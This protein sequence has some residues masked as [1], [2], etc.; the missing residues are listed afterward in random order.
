MVPSEALAAFES[1]VA[2]HY[3]WN[4]RANL[5]YGLFGTTGLRLIAAPTFVPDYL[6]KLGG[7][8]LVVGL[9]LVVGG[10]CRF[11][12]PMFA[13]AWV[14]HRSHVKPYS[15]AIGMLM[16]VAILGFALAALVLPPATNLIAFIVCLGLFHFSDGMQTVAYS[17]VMGKVIP[18]ARRGR[19]IGL[20]DFLGGTTVA[21]LSLPMGRLLERVPFP[22][23]YGVMFLI[24]LALTAIGLVC[25]SLTR[26][27]P[28]P[29]PAEPQSAIDTLRRI[30]DVLRQDRRFASY[31]ASRA[32]GTAALTATPF[33]V[34]YAQSSLALTGTRLGEFTFLFFLAQTVVNPLWGRLA[35]GRGFR[36]VSLVAAGVWM[37]AAALLVVA[38]HSPLLVGI[39]FAIVGIGHGGYRMAAVNMVF[40]FGLDARFAQRLA[41]VSMIGELVGAV[42]PLGTGLLADHAG[43]PAALLS[44][45]M[46]MAIAQVV[47]ALGVR[48]HRPM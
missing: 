6:Y 7:S 14:A 31:C 44:A 15:V 2:R 21:V 48:G 30:P 20:R 45:V 12:G 28:A 17:L 5:V 32:L 23:S 1:A 47:M 40:E 41:A 29:W 9:A 18:L 34:L 24:A 33:F 22:T 35:D 4:V 13:A 3:A 10:V 37:L 42:A 16:R 38:S 27:P 36:V 8:N 11:V 39:V 43:Y 26:E 19:F 25:F 46:V